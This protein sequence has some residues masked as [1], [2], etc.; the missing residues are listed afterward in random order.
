M[1]SWFQPLFVAAAKF[2]LPSVGVGWLM[3][4]IVSQ[5]TVG[6]KTTNDLIQ[7]HMSQAQSMMLH[8]DQETQQQR[9]YL[10][11]LLRVCIN[12]ARNDADRIACVSTTGK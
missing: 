4:V 1:P 5:V 11:V 7:S 9:E 6:Q 10:G 8:F 3:W 12:T 2:G